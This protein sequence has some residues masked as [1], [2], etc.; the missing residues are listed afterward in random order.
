[1]IS[2]SLVELAERRQGFAKL[3]KAFKA[4]G[5]EFW[6]EGGPTHFDLWGIVMEPYFLQINS[7]TAEII[8][9]KSLTK[10]SAVEAWENEV[11]S[12]YCNV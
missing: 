12:L 3:N 2:T 10:R 11:S 4:L 7:L 1:M 5:D 8:T 9:A 6:T